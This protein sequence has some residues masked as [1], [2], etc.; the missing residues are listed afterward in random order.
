MKRKGSFLPIVI[1]IL[2]SIIII[3]ISPLIY[4]SRFIT[5][6]VHKNITYDEAKVL[7]VKKEA[8]QPDPKIHTIDLGYQ[9]I[10]VEIIKGKYAGRQFDI[11]NSISRIYNIKVKQGMKVV[12][13][14]YTDNGAITDVAVYSH[15][16]DYVIYTL[17]AIFFVIV[18]AVGRLKGFKSLI[19]LIF[20]GI[21]VIFFMMPLIFRGVNP[22]LAAIITA[23]MT[24][25]AMMLLIGDS[26]KKIYSA[27][28]GAILGVVTAGL[29]SYI[30][31]KLAHLSGLTMEDAEN[32]LYIAENSSL[33]VEGL[34]FASILIASLGAIMDMSM[35]ITSAIFE[36]HAANP[37]LTRKELFEGGMNVG[38]DVIGTMA[39]TL[40][41]AFAG[42]S[43]TLLILVI[44]AKMPYAQLANLDVIN[45]ELIQALS[46]SIGIV[47]TVP[48]T[49]SITAI[50]IKNNKVKNEKSFSKKGQMKK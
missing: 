12:V 13:G 10:K 43:L 33:Q 30:S 37:K 25:T 50:I 36:I 46:G 24:T 41:L 11:K 27:V 22:I 26:K 23:V 40:I 49:A 7:E 17:I 4:P 14:I 20:T 21:T 32:I 19:A 47:L 18:I 48:I 5:D 3:A 1:I 8:L 16:R 29:I 15:K 35:S 9:D 28:F 2:L 39:N 34:M 31:G 45:T 6:R 44:A 42:S 38:R